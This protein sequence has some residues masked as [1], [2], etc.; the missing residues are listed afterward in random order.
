MSDYTKTR[1]PCNMLDDEVIV[2]AECRTRVQNV[3]LDSL[4]SLPRQTGRSQG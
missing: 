2:R 4:Q 3:I 1:K